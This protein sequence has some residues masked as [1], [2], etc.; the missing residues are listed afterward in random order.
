MW[1]GCSVHPDAGAD[2]AHNPIMSSAP[3]ASDAAGYIS[4]GSATSG[5]GSG[6]GSGGVGVKVGYVSQQA[7]IRNCTL[8][9]NI[10]L[11]APFIEDRYW[12][13]I[14]ACQLTRDLDILPAGD[15]TEIGER[16]VNLSGEGP[17]MLY[18]YPHQPHD[19]PPH[20]HPLTS[21]SSS[22]QS[23]LCQ[24]GSSRESHWHVRCTF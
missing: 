5:A 9:D 1:P 6:R 8:R 13:V 7:W 11:G 14:D 22:S 18:C 24:A 19:A 3:S 12:E 23:P 20:R 17:T 4:L 16:G 2:T 21:H 15:M 10:L